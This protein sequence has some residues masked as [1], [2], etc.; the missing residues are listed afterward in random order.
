ME[1]KLAIYSQMAAGAG[2][3][4]LGSSQAA[5]ILA[6]DMPGM[7][8]QVVRTRLAIF[9]A[10]VTVCAAFAAVALLIVIASKKVH[11]DQD[12]KEIGESVG[13]KDHEVSS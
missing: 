13:E 2:A 7:M 8:S 1:S 12:Q 6:P 9:L 3:V 5:I 10:S 4:V 11:Q